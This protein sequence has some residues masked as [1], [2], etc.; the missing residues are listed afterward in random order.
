MLVNRKGKEIRVSPGW[1]LLF[2]LKD[3]TASLFDENGIR[4]FSGDDDKFYIPDLDG[5][6]DCINLFGFIAWSHG[7]KVDVRTSSGDTLKFEFTE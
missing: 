5:Y 2:N 1:T 4:V 7:L 3:K 6:G